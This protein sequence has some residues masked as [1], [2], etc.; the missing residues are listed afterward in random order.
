[1]Y[2]YEYSALYS[3]PVYLYIVR[4]SILPGPSWDIEQDDLRLL[5]SLTHTTHDTTHIGKLNT[6]LLPF[7]GSI[8]CH[9]PCKGY[10]SE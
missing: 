4:I 1:M 9:P 7:S 10:H 5:I 3:T 2:M 6:M 8:A